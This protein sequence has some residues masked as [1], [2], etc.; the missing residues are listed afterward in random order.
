[1]QK[2]SS[3]KQ[4]NLFAFFLSATY[5]VSYLTRIN[6]GTVILEMVTDTGFSKSLLS[7]ALTGSFITY[8]T[9]QIISG[10]LGDRISPKKL[11]TMGFFI[12]FTMNILIPICT[13]PYQMTAVWCVNGFAQAFMWPPIVK[14]MTNYLSEK[15]YAESTAKVSWGSSVGTI[16]I[17]LIS[18]I[19]ISVS[20]W[21]AV[22]FFSAACAVIMIILWS[23]TSYDVIPEKKTEKVKEQP[24]KIKSPL[25]S[26]TMIFIMFAIILQGMLRDGI[27][28]WM[29]SYIAETFKLSNIISI[30]TGIILPIF[31][32]ITFYLATKLYIN[33]FTNPILCAAFFFAIGAIS[34]L[35][36][37]LLSSTSAAISVG[38]SAIITASMH[39][40]NIMLICIVPS[41]FSK[42]G[43]ISTT[44]G[45]LNSC[46]YVGSAL[47]TYGVAL[48][49]DLI[50]WSY[51][52]LIWFIV[53][54]IGTMICLFF[55]KSFMKKFDD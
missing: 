33:K 9:G 34:S 47:F 35:G 15:D 24:K 23:K 11:V 12:T 2:L 38:L 4:V 54:A 22:F 43:N 20:S 48:L 16:I 45:V 25:F 29:P 27:T 21:R 49:S 46:T 31:S 18:P 10:I 30:L 37:F 17:Y 6:Y 36:L 40:V 44:S 39:G 52:I 53:A 55:A 42:Y 3:K 14:L 5:M 7:M 1:M 26:V 51:T 19:I 8:G 13:T 50:G 32:I 41:Y 28:T